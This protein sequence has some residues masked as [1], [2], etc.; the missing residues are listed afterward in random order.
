MGFIPAATIFPIFPVNG[1]DRSLHAPVMIGLLAITFFTEVFG[2]T[3]AGLVVPGYL[4]TV[5]VAAPITGAL[6]VLEALLTYLFAALIGRWLPRTGAWSTTFG[7]ER[8][9]LFIVGAVL[10]RLGVEGNLLP[11][12]TATFGLHHSRELYS[13]GLVLVPLLANM[14]WNTG[15]KVAVPRV[16]VVTAI[17]WLI[18]EYVLLRH[19]NFTISRFEVANESVSLTFLESPHAHIILLLG[20]LLGAR[21]NVKYGWDYNGILVPALL[22]VAWYSP[23][24]LLTT[25]VEALLVYAGAKLLTSVPPMSRWLIVG[26]RRMVMTFLIGFFVKFVVGF[27]IQWFDWQVQLVDWFGFGYLLPSLLAVKMWN[28]DKIGV[29][30]MPTVQVSAIAFLVGNAV[31]FGFSQ[32]AP[33]RARAELGFR[34]VMPAQIEPE[35]AL[36]LGS[37]APHPRLDEA[38]ASS[39]T[40]GAAVRRLVSRLGSDGTI[41]DESLTL[42]WEAGMQVGRSPTSRDWLSLTPHAVD[43]NADVVAPRL[44]LRVPTSRT[45][46]WLLIV[47]VRNPGDPCIVLG[48]AL[49]RYLGVRAV[50]LQQATGPQA[51]LDQALAERLVDDLDIAQVMRVRAVTAES[52][53]TVVGAGPAGFD[54]AG[55]GRWLGEELRFGWRGAAPAKG[56]L[57]RAMELSVEDSRVQALASGILG[58]SEVRTHEG[59]F[60][61]Y[62]AEHVVELTSVG[63]QGQRAPTLEEL[64][65]FQRTV[66]PTWLTL[67]DCT[68]SAWQRSLARLLGYEWL[69]FEG[70][71]SSVSC[72]LLEPAGPNRRGLPTLW[73]RVVP[74]VATAGNATASDLALRVPSPRWEA[75]AVMAGLR[76]LEGQ[77]ASAMLIMGATPDALDVASLDRAER[78]LASYYEL[79]TEGWLQSGGHVLTVLG[80]APAHPAP[81]DAILS[82]GFE[83]RQLPDWLRPVERELQ[84]AGLSTRLFDGGGATAAFEGAAEPGQPYAARFAPGRAA[85]LWLSASARERLRQID[86]KGTVLRRLE[87]V[88]MEPVTASAYD[89]LRWMLACSRTAAGSPQV[90]GFGTCP[91]GALQK[92]RSCVLSEASSPWLEYARSSNPFA[93]ASAVRSE[94]CWSKAVLDVNSGNSWL[95]MVG[96]G[97][98]VAVPLDGGELA[99]EPIV[100][101]DPAVQRAAFAHATA[102]LETGDAP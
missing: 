102:V 29:V 23:S 17:T 19:T 74:A 41:D 64:R 40:P 15:A 16:A 48:T 94:P 46:P 5:M 20:A 1:L 31:G 8:F 2:W 62:L 89:Y 18:V 85:L 68:P 67:G 70:G 56:P 32:L 12:L 11:R 44:A 13:L 7:R 53:L 79:A 10:V 92:L 93:L 95:L 66:L 6:I 77:Q 51:Q 98:G 75:G 33:A 78:V 61:R 52:S 30:L 26:P 27:L 81:S 87:R 65:L 43:P 82:L 97:R 86:T 14:F 22:A 73:R 63:G 36:L 50:F 37:T 3:Y 59:G 80:I 100:S 96:A 39:V 28:K 71:S 42:A 83:T 90:A 55:L 84:L 24:K 4:A 60:P 34:P 25:V 88:G 47:E 57:G 9:F 72:A 69:R 101:S 49:G 76:L 91:A 54:V 38:S 35:W 99:V 58:T 45:S 21:N